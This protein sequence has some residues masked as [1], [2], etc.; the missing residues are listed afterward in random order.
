MYPQFCAFPARHAEDDP[1]LAAVAADFDLGNWRPGAILEVQGDLL[2]VLVGVDGQTAWLPA[3]E[4]RQGLPEEAVLGFM[5]AVEEAIED[6]L[7]TDPVDLAR[8]ARL[9]ETLDLL[10]QCLAEQEI[11]ESE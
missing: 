9:E 10:E 7:D 11:G 4:T 5:D 2:K 8:V 3:T 6:T 1:Y